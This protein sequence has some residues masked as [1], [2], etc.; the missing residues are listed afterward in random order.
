LGRPHSA[1]AWCGI[2]VGTRRRWRTCRICAGADQRASSVRHSCADCVRHS[3][4]DCRANG[5][6]CAA[7]TLGGTSRSVCPTNFVRPV[8][9]DAC[10][11]AAVIA[12]KGYG[13][14]GVYPYFPVGCFWHTITGS[15]YFNTHKSGGS[16]YYAQPL[17]AGAARPIQHACPRTRTHL[18]TRMHA[19]THT[20]TDTL[21]RIPA[22]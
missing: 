10:T 21:A 16:N 5:V 2:L 11:S 12:G 7:F 6:F 3:C 18:H 19:Q 4:A 1:C 22:C 17:C 14:T 15:V 8:A 13:G 9:E 20:R